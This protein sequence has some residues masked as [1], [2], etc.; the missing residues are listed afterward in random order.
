MATSIE[1]IVG[2]ERPALTITLVDE[3]N[4]AIDLSGFIGSI[5]LGLDTTTTALTKSSGVSCGTDGVTVTWTAGDLN[6]DP[7]TY[8]GQVTATNGARDYIQQFTLV[9]KPALA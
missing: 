8:L 1:Y 9:L 2:A 4:Q 5:S 3:S 7:G 6:L